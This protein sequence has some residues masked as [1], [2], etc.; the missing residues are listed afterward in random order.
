MTL[1]ELLKRE[2]PV[3]LCAVQD[4]DGEAV[5]LTVGLRDYY[6]PTIQDAIDDYVQAANLEAR[7]CKEF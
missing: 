7:R 3:Q 1:D 2:S 6:G 5:R 4:M